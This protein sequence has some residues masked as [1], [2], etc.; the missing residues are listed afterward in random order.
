MVAVPE[1]NVG[2]E[3]GFQVSS[4]KSQVLCAT[5]HASRIT[6][7]SIYPIIHS[8]SHGSLHWSSR[9]H[10]PPIRRSHFWR[11]EISRAPQLRSRRAWSEITPQTHRLRP[12]PD[13]KAEASLLL[14]SA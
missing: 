7:Q 6:Y 9:S 11:I 8:L 12:G 3:D 13:R 2:Y 10:Q 4:L 1:R 14:R 5:H